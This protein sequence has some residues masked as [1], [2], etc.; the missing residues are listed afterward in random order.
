MS[1]KLFDFSGGGRG[2]RVPV[3]KKQGRLQ[4]QSL[5]QIQVL[6]SKMKQTNKFSKDLY[7]ERLHLHMYVCIIK[8]RPQNTF[9]MFKGEGSRL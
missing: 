2:E 6:L 1:L 9:K 8:K 5:H 4:L 7:L 3:H